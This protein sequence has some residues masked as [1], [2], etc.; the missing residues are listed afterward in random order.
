MN[1][2]L[3]GWQG[4][5]LSAGDKLVLVKSVF[6]ALPVYCFAMIV[7]PIATIYDMQKILSSFFGGTIVE[8]KDTTG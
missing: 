3:E 2:K 4:K 5:I 7:P 1:K 6:S 8:I